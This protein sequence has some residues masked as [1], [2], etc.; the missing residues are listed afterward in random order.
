MTK[1]ELENPQNNFQRNTSNKQLIFQQNNLEDLFQQFIIFIDATPNTVRTYRGSLKQWFL[2]LRQNQIGHP[3]SETVRQ[4]RQKLQNSGKKPTTVKNYIIAVKR[5]FEW[6][7]EAGFY[8]N[9]AK[10]IKS[11][12]LSKNF[13]K[14][15]LTGSQARQILDKIDRSTIKG[16]RDYAMLV[17]MLTMGLRTIE[18]SRADIDD[19]RTKGNMTVLYVQG[20]GH[21][22]KDDLIRM[23]QHVESAIRDYLSVRKA[24]DLS[25]PLFVSTSNH[26][27]NGRMTTRSI[28]R[29]VKTAFISAGYDSPRLTAHSTRHTA[30]T[31]SLLNGA[32][33]QQTQELLRHRN[34]GTTEIYAHNI[35]AA[36]NPAANDVEEAIFGKDI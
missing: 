17:T 36:T 24:N 26:N 33:L 4:Y 10:Y 20:K 8:P 11:G 34:I 5:F 22:E 19:I 30:A 3:D 29:I 31:L 15:Y 1:N 7:E 2:Y 32:T 27:A 6:T 16:K 21:E 28:R 12:H 13:K 9:I 14:D 23:P 18:V 35:D 25:K